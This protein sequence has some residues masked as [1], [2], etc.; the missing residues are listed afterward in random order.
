MQKAVSS[1]YFLMTTGV[2]AILAAAGAF[3]F[4]ASSDECGR[5]G[6]PAL[7]LI[8]K[9]GEIAMTEGIRASISFVKDTVKPRTN[10][11]VAHMAMHMVGHHAYMH[12]GDLKEALKYLPVGD[13]AIE[14][15]LEFNG[16]QHG[17][18]EAFFAA[19]KERPTRDLMGE[20]CA[21]H[22]IPS[23]EVSRERSIL[24]PEC[25]HAVGH[26]LMYILDNDVPRALAACDEAPH[27]W[28]QEWCYHGVF[29][30]NHY[31]HIPGYLEEAPKP[32]AT[33]VKG[34][35]MCSTLDEKYRS[36][37]SQFVGW[38][39]MEIYPGDFDGAFAACRKFG[40]NDARICIART[41]RFHLASQFR[42]DFSAI[43]AACREAAFFMDACLQ[44]AAI[45]VRE[46]IAGMEQQ[47]VS[48]CAV[49]P[50][51]ER[52]VCE[53]AVEHYRDSLARIYVTEL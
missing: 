14:E 22:M 34:I 21:D 11:K 45:G 35:E 44:G 39:Y 27:Q 42:E 28:M 16:Y 47:N 37:C 48:F 20:A 8:E 18:F 13:A 31:L 33:G 12:G 40:E 1:K 46:G 30:E 29:M 43:I 10:Y 9:T 32:Y 23:P 5:S 3:W 49:V 41:A 17:V 53:D 7:C 15:F 50:S 2:V 19:N 26:S 36:S 38:V 24:G 51:E 25:F 52:G 4:Q 6:T